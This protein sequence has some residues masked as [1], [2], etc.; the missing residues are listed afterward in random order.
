MAESLTDRAR[1]SSQNSYE[2]FLIHLAVPDCAFVI[3]LLQ[4]QLQDDADAAVQLRAVDMQ[5]AEGRKPVSS[6]QWKQRPLQQCLRRHK[7]DASGCTPAFLVYVGHEPAPLPQELHQP[8]CRCIVLPVLLEVRCELE[9][10]GRDPGNLHLCRPT[11]L[12]VPLEGRHLAQV[13]ACAS[14]S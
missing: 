1:R 9:Y 14:V 11:V 8:A 6:R 4:W 5:A 2:G 10:S 7:R 12:F 3:S 13:S